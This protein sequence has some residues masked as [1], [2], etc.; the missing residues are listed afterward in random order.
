MRN[1]S[2]P[3]SLHLVLEDMMDR[4]A[5]AG[6]CVVQSEPLVILLTPLYSTF[7]T[8]VEWVCR[9]EATSPANVCPAGTLQ[10]HTNPQYAERRRSVRSQYRVTPAH[11]TL[12][13]RLT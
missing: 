2:L 1:T 4:W 7:Y 8:S 12:N 13:E 10:S 3:Q 5:R 11:P 6:R 9:K